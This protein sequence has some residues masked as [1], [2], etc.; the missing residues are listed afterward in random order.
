MRKTQLQQTITGNRPGFTLVE[1]LVTISIFIILLAI[2][3]SAFNVGQDREKITGAARQI[4]SAVEGARSRAFK[5]QRPIGLRFNIDPSDPTVSPSMIYVQQLEPITGTLDVGGPSLTPADTPDEYG[6][7]EIQIRTVD[8]LPDAPNGDV[9]PKDGYYDSTFAHGDLNVLVNAVNQGLITPGVTIRIRGGS[10]DYGE[11]TIISRPVRFCY[12]SS[13]PIDMAIGD[14]FNPAAGRL[15][16]FPRFRSPGSP[17]TT[18]DYTNT[19]GKV[20]QS[21]NFEIIPAAI[22]LQNEE[23]LIFPQGVVID[24]D[25]SSYPREWAKI[26]SAQTWQQNTKYSVGQWVRNGDYYFKCVDFGTSSNS[27]TAPTASGPSLIIQDGTVYW[28]SYSSPQLDLMF[29]PRGSAIGSVSTNGL[30]SFGLAYRRD[31]DLQQL[32]GGVV[33]HSIHDARK[34]PDG[35]FLFK[36]D[37]RISTLF[38]QSGAVITNEPDYTDVIVNATGVSGTDNIADNPFRYVFEGAESK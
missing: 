28:R 20:I 31:T 30:I 15:F 2:T 13:T 34:Q 26:T 27:G 23:P 32:V 25:S 21:L 5:L 24:W 7:S 22:P 19:R 14:V 9:A 35:K 16:I 6:F 4:Q 29:S 10:T 33:Q 38:L 3:A 12:P 17:R 1:L 8:Q 11:Y 36:G 18:V 37:H